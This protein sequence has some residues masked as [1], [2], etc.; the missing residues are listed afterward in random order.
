MTVQ[1]VQ[2]ALLT[3]AV[4]LV[5]NGVAGEPA[6]PGNIFRELRCRELGRTAGNCRARRA[7]ARIKGLF[8]NVGGAGMAAC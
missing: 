8:G 4:T 1:G 6:S 3:R 2:D 7:V 5:R